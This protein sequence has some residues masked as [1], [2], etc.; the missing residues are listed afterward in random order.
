[1]ILR[2]HSS[3]VC[4]FYS[5]FLYLRHC[6]SKDGSTV[7]ILPGTRYWTIYIVYSTFARGYIANAVYEVSFVVVFR[8]CRCLH[9]QVLFMYDTT[10]TQQYICAFFFLYLRQCCSSYDA[11]N[12]AIQ[13]YHT[14]FTTAPHAG[15]HAPGR[16][17][18]HFD[19]FDSIFDI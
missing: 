19:L 11:I 5:F 1:M 18:Q 2:Q 14:L 4:V 12:T 3:T 7:I 13:Y 6:C 16:A 9:L 17:G 15:T 10:A 8:F